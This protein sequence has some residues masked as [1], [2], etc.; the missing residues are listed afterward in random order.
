MKSIL[1]ITFTGLLLLI[2]VGCGGGLEQ[3]TPSSSAPPPTLSEQPDMVTYHKYFSELG[4]GK[5]P[6]EIKDPVADLQKNVSVFTAGDLICLYGTITQKCQPRSKV[7]NVSTGK[8]VK[9]GGLPQPMDGGFAGWEPIDIP[10]GQ[11]EYKVYVGD[12]LVGVFP[13][14]VR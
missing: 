3:T 5:M 2:I 8:V 11:Y 14:E 12:I 10:A 9:E 6:A 7:Y 1:L 13:F 4:I